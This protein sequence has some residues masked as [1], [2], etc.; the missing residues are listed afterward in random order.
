MFQ[1]LTFEVFTPIR[2]EHPFELLSE[3]MVAVIF[4]LGFIRSFF[5]AVNSRRIFGMQFVEGFSTNVVRRLHPIM[6]GTFMF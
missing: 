6:L 5:E 1:H 2:L 4:V 3:N